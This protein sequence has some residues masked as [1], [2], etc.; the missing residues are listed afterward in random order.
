MN[1]KFRQYKEIYKNRFLSPLHAAKR[2][3]GDLPGGHKKMDRK[4]NA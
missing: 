4:I 1:L 3:G 2:E